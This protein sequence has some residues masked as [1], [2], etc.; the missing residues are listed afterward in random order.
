MDSYHCVT[1]TAD[2]FPKVNY[3]VSFAF[4]KYQPDPDKQDVIRQFGL[5]KYGQALFL[6]DADKADADLGL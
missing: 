4:W 2:N 5:D 6:P 1:V 3:D